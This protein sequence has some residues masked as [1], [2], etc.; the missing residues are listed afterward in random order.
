MGPK[1]NRLWLKLATAV[2]EFKSATGTKLCSLPAE[3]F[4]KKLGIPKLDI[5]HLS[6]FG[7]L[8]KRE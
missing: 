7:F 3:S 5:E 1:E 8:S 6:Y 4:A 2:V